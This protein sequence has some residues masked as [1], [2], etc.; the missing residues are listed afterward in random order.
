M[1]GQNAT[2]APRTEDYN[3]GRGKVYFAPLV[4]GVPGAFRDLGNSPEFNISMETE[5]LD[6]MSSREGL[7]ITDKQVVISQKVSV[8]FQLDEINFENVGM[9][10]SGSSGSRA[11][12]GGSAITG[13]GNL[14]VTDQ[15]RWYDL[16]EGAT[17]PTKTA[18]KRI[19]DIGEVTIEPHGGGSALVEDTDFTVDHETGRIF[20]IDGGDME[21]GT[22]DVDVA[23]NALASATV[24]RVKALDT[25][26]QLGC[27][28]FISENPT[29]EDKWTEYTF[30]QV[31]LSASGDFALIGDDW[32][33]LT[34][35][36]LAERNAVADPV[37][38]TLTIVTNP[39]Q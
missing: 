6:H 30:H 25:N 32:T 17:A 7:K 22:Y 38:P 12:A 13:N 4:S 18:D 27:L 36:G 1:A 9:W 3:L 19:Y 23:L 14:V 16:Y 39:N 11:N 35:E 15:G 29:D 33:A 10:F 8:S 5:K 2:G 24:D 37:S 20:V 28:R 21:A 34:F 26:A 31:R